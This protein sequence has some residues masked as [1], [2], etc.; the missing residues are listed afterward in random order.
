[1]DAD[2]SAPLSRKVVIHSTH[3][4][5]QVLW[6][7]SPVQNRTES[8]LKPSLTSITFAPAMKVFILEKG[9]RKMLLTCNN[10]VWNLVSNMGDLVYKVLAT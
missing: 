7:F 4:Q 3:P 9:W 1:M 6:E 8:F 10:V 2:P 5:G